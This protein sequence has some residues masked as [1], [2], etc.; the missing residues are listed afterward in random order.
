MEFCT[1]CKKACDSTIIFPCDSCNK[2][3]CAT[4]G[5]LTASEIKCLQLK[6]KR[7]L[8]FYCD[9]C[10]EGLCKVPSL[11]KEVADLKD[12][13]N[14]INEM[15]SRERINNNSANNSNCN[16]EDIISEMLDR[17]NRATNVI[18]YNMNQSVRNTQTERI[19]EDKELVL[20][21]LSE[22]TVEKNN[23]KV[24][25]LGK[26]Q[27]NKV[28]PIKVILN[29]VADARLILKNKNSISRHGVRI[30]SDETKAQREYFQ[31]IKAELEAITAGGDDTKTIRYINNKPTIVA[32]TI[33]TRRKN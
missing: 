2:L 24:F 17:Q 26:F 23:L 19:H 1:N 25:R 32:K 4:C 21:V 18:M 28:R 30:S 27:P 7:K 11:I 5:D 6:N 8:K 13:V 15:L 16:M 12:S 14:K 20:R 3:F 10:E 22:L 31:K 9:A 29:S 33:Q